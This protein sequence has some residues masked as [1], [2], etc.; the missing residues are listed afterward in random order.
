MNNVKIY[1]TEMDENW[2]DVLVLEKMEP[3]RE[4]N[5]FDNAEK[6]A[7]MMNSI[8]NLY[9]QSEEYVYLIALDAKSHIRGISEI[10]HGG[11]SAAYVDVRSVFQ[12]ALLL[13]AVNVILVHNHPGKDP[14]P[15]REDVNLTKRLIDAGKILQVRFLDHIIVSGLKNY[16]SLRSDSDITTW[17]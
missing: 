9:K 13:G 14:S 11:V 15:S 4:E 1:K 8:F 16:Y 5:T 10:A 3:Y 6:I 12:K 2:M 17:S 7:D